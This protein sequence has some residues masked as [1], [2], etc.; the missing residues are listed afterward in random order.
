[1]KSYTPLP[2][3]YEVR[4]ADQRGYVGTL[5]A[6]NQE[7]FVALDS[8]DPRFGRFIQIARQHLNGAPLGMKVLVELTAVLSDEEAHGKIIEVL[9]DPGQPDVAITG[10][11]RSY[12]LREAFPAEVLQE[13]EGLPVNPDP[14]QVEAE[15]A[16][17]RLDLR[18][19]E[20]YTVDGLDARDL[21]DA[22]AV[23][24]LGEGY[25]LWV[26]I[27]DV[28]HYVRPRTALDKEAFQRANSVYLVDR[29]LP[30]LPPKLSNGLCSLNPGQDR[31]CLSCRIDY[32]SQGRVL[33]GQVVKTVIQSKLRS[34]YEELREIFAGQVPEDLP[35]WFLDSVNLA[36]ELSAL[37]AARRKQ[38]GALVFD[39]PE[40]K[41]SLDAEGKVKDIYGEKQDEANQIIESFMIAANEYIAAYCDEHRLAAIYRVHE[42]P[43][44]EKMDQVLQYV[45]D[46]GLGFRIPRDIDPKNLQQLLQKLKDEPYGTTL[47]EMLLRALAK[48]RYDTEDLGHFGLASLQYCH[49]TA[50]IRRYADVVVHRAVKAHLE[51]QDPAKRSKGLKSVA[52]HISEMERVAV[53]AERDSYDQ[54]IVEYYADKLGEIYEGVIAGFSNSS[55]F[56]QLPNTVE[57]AVLYASVESGYIQY[58]ADHLLAHNRDTGTYYQLG[59]PVTIQVAKVDQERRFLDFKLLKHQET[60]LHGLPGKSRKRSSSRPKKHKV[61]SRGKGRRSQGGQHRIGRG[62]Q[63]KGRIK[64]GGKRKG[65]KR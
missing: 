55:L 35:A 63:G 65:R 38:R 10:I 26:H 47:S 12:L 43:P 28:T 44:L 18:A 46:L 53:E 45:Q 37:L 6:K 58:D 1:M 41:I 42:D 31:L 13:V 14:D 23:E 32:D 49:F 7:H 2:E 27:A 50:P 16:Q 20:T 36:R 62:K 30:M 24:R 39:F 40:T 61:Q 56:V 33:A 54:K 51:G 60:A 4:L 59:D 22:I 34:S 25:R 57:G 17:G 52:E 5:Q 48:A 64:Q 8:P 9:G 21:D 11:I 29:V 3:G 19:Q 15:L